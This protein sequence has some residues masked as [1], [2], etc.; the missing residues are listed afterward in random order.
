MEITVEQLKTIR[1]RVEQLFIAKTG[2][3]PDC[4]EIEEDGQFYCQ[5]T[6]TW[7]GD[8]ECIT[9]YITVDDLT[10]DLDDHIRIRKAKEEEERI[11][12]E[13]KRQEDRA[14]YEEIKKAERKKQY[15]ALRKEFEA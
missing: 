15:E 5:Y 1:G 14:R 4:V 7:R 10:S 6:W 11:K 2:H 3:K 12:R 9:E 8:S 13:K